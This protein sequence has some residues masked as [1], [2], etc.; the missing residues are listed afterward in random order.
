MYDDQLEMQLE[1]FQLEFQ[2]IRNVYLWNARMVKK[3]LWEKFT[4]LMD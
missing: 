3:N 2:S 1:L 4:A